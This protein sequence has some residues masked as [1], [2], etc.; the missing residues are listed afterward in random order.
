MF[1]YFFS[2]AFAFMLCGCAGGNV[3]FSLKEKDRKTICYQ[4]RGPGYTYITL[5]SSENKKRQYKLTISC[6]HH[7]SYRIS[8][9]EY[10]IIDKEQKA[11]DYYIAVTQIN[12]DKFMC[13]DV[14]IDQDRI[15]TLSLLMISN[16]EKILFHLISEEMK[17]ITDCQL[18]DIAN[19]I[20]FVKFKE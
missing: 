14:E 10:N 9:R 13:F 7:G 3:L 1:K 20:G 4:N 16:K 17:K 2:Y 8:K 18:Y 12:Q 15:D 5:S 11:N 6:T 19:V